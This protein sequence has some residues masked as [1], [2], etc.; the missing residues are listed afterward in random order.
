MSAARIAVL[1]GGHGECEA[2]PVLI[3]RIAAEKQPPVSVEILT[4]IRVHEDRARKEGELERYVELAARKLGGTGGIFILFDCDWD[5]SCPKTD[6]PPLLA[7]THRVRPN[8]PISLVLAHREFESWFIAASRSLGGKRGLAPELEFVDD[9]ERI[10]GAKEWLRKQMPRSRPYTETE[11]QPALTAEFDMQEAQRA[12]SFEK[13]YRELT[14]LLSR[15][16]G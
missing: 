12:P 2:V 5:N 10:R 13:C 11:D 3:R 14:S 6:A 8:L 16:G 7:R 1:V 4:P 15:L 9:P